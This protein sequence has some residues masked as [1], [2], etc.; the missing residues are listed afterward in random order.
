MADQVTANPGLLMSVEE[1]HDRLGDDNL[2]IVD[3]RAS[4]LFAAGCGAFGFVWH[5]FEQHV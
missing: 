5:Q 1:L 3:A 4:H 2:C